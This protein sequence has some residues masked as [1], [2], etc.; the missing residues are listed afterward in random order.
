MGNHDQTFAGVANAKPINSFAPR[1]GLGTHKLVLLAFRVKDSNKNEGKILESDFMVLESATEEPGST[2]GWPWF[3]GKAGWTGTYE[4]ARAKEF[5]DTV[6]ECIGDTRGT[7]AIGSDLA[8]EAQSGRGLTIIAEVTNGNKKD[9]DGNPYKNI[10]WK[11]VPQTLAEIAAMRA[12]IDG[13][14][15]AAEPVAA[16]V[17]P[18]V[19]PPAA[20]PAAGLGGL[21]AMLAAAKK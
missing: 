6:G 7:Q 20:A 4:T 19:A 17:A 15:P 13:A 3:I 21:A 9:K 18:P 2:R 5:L 11:K 14:A 12:M 8:S 10:S 1:F 16:P